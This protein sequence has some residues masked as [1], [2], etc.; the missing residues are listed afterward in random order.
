[1]VVPIGVMYVGEKLKDV[2]DLEWTRKVLRPSTLSG[3]RLKDKVSDRTFL[4]RRPRIPAEDV[5]ML[6]L[7]YDIFY[8]ALRRHESMIDDDYF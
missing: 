7:Q 4:D 5:N 1:V 6:C 8:K 2:N 3:R